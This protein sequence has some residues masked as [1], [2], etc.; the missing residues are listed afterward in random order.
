MCIK[1]YRRWKRHGDPLSK[2]RSTPGMSVEEKLKF[3]MDKETC[4]HTTGCW[5]WTGSLDPRGYG[6]LQV[7]GKNYM[8]HRLVWEYWMDSDGIPDHLQYRHDPIGQ[9]GCPKRCV[10]IHHGTI[11]TNRDNH[12]DWD[13]AGDRHYMA[14]VSDFN[15]ERA[16]RLYRKGGVTYKEVAARFGVC[17]STIGRWVNGKARR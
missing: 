9:I 12:N 5:L 3:H 4:R 16:V 8:A 7:R 6:V 15:K 2:V 14:T 1:H 10:N 13:V 17:Y 11:G